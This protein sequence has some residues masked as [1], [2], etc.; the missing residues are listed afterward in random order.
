MM[1]I[2]IRLPMPMPM[3]YAFIP[4]AGVN[5]F[6]HIYIQFLP[7][8]YKEEYLLLDTLLRIG[9]DEGQKIKRN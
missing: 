3:H 6:L 2:G 8:K 7:A 4:G 9:S 5:L 1:G